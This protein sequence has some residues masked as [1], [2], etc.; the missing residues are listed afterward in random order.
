MVLASAE[1]VRN[2]SE[3]QF[4]GNY[5]IGAVF[6][7]VRGDLKEYED[8]VGGGF[9][10]VAYWQCEDNF[11]FMDEEIRDVPHK[12]PVAL[13][14]SQGIKVSELYSVPRVSELLDKE[15][16]GGGVAFDLKLG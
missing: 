3:L 5:T 16:L 9:Y 6:W 13:R 1:Q 15:G 11:G 7:L 8:Q 10:I 14:E 12:D 4:D 2:A